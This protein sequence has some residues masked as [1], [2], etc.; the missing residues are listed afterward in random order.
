[1]TETVFAPGP[2][3]VELSGAIKGMLDDWPEDRDAM[4]VTLNMTKVQWAELLDALRVGLI[5]QGLE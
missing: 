1:M 2:V 4:Q 5:E 3:A